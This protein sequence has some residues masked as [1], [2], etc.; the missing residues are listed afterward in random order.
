MNYMYTKVLVSILTVC[1]ACGMLKSGPKTALTEGVSVCDL[2]TAAE[3][4]AVQN[5]AY[6][7]ANKSNKSAGGL[8]TFQCFY[9]LPTF[10]KSVSLEIVQSADASGGGVQEFWKKRFGEGADEE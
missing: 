8:E 9:R 1:C 2:L 10:N 4:E 7:D 3:I 5:E 6:L